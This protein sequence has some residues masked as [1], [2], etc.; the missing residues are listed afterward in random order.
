[1]ILTKVHIKNYKSILDTKEFSLQGDYVVLAGKNESGKSNILKALEK[2]TTKRFYD[3]EKP[4]GLKEWRPQIIY[5]FKLNTSEQEEIFSDYEIKADENDEIVIDVGDYYFNMEYLS[6]KEKLEQLKTS[7]LVEFVKSKEIDFHYSKKKSDE[8]LD[9]LESDI[10]AVVNNTESEGCDLEFRE[11]KKHL[12]ELDQKLHESLQ[13]YIPQVVY[14]PD[15]KHLLPSSFNETDLDGEQS[16]ML[17]R[18]QTYLETDFRCIFNERDLDSRYSLCESLS[19][20]IDKDFK[21]IFKQNRVKI[22]LT[23]DQDTITIRVKDIETNASGDYESSAIKINERSE[24]FQWYFNFF[25]TLKGGGLKPGDIILIDEPGVY[26]HPKA[27][28]DML[29]F[30]KKQSEQY[31]IIFTSHSPYLINKDD[32]SHLRLI[33]KENLHGEDMFKETLVR[34]KIHAAKDKDTLLPIID[35]IGYAIPDINLNFRTIIITEGVS[36]YYYIKKI[37]EINDIDFSKM[38]ITFANSADKIEDLYTMYLG[39]GFKNIVVI[40]DSDAK[41]KQIYKNLKKNLVENV[42]FINEMQ[43][44]NGTIK[45]NGISIEDL[46]TNNTLKKNC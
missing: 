4:I 46:V 38:N 31:Q 27:Q 2:L 42:Y 22:I 26:L 29:E 8:I 35:A 18:L 21:T 5:K 11:L 37:M 9:I 20:N 1:M 28:L 32:L 12:K 14:H 24:G 45:G 34:E 30:I 19:K 10:F 41:G 36:D 39:L 23:T 6:L 3:N 16:V 40:L 15:F 7:K 43:I 33:E 13:K 44:E 25:I 17:K